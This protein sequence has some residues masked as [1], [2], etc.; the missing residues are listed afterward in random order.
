MERTLDR[1]QVIVTNWWDPAIAVCAC[2]FVVVLAVAA[3][4]DASI[5][6]VHVFEALP[7]IAAAILCARQRKAGYAL[8][9]MAGLL[10]LGLAGRGSTFIENGFQVIA[11]SL[12]TH[13]V[14]RPDLLIAVPGALATTGLTVFSAIGYGQLTNRRLSDAALF[15]GAA[16][17]VTAFFFGIFALFSPQ[18]LV[19]LKHLFSI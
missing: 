17:F 6:V 16:I 4:W 13:N 2:M 10:W 3:Y 5:R 19:P 7:Y 11:V 14:V 15:G 9:V 8:G 12:R 18:F 1:P